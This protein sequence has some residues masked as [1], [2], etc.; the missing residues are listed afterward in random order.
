[1]VRAA[2]IGAWMVSNQ[3]CACFKALHQGPNSKQMTSVG[4]IFFFLHVGKTGF[5]EVL[6]KPTKTVREI[7]PE[8]IELNFSDETKPM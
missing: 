5:C 2:L 7:K 6:Q 4:Y 8:G 1:M 3:C